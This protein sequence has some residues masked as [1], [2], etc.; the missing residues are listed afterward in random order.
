MEN[1]IRQYEEEYRINQIK[2]TKNTNKENDHIE[3]ENQALIKNQ[4]RE[5][6]QSE[7]NKKLL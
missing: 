2:I 5:S 6:C 4:I 7:C 3:S 1:E